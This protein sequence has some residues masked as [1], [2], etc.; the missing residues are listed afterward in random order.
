[1]AAFDPQKDYYAVLGVS[2]DADD[3]VIKQAYRRQARLYHPDSG[4]GNT[5]MLSLIHI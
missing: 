5:D 1:M 2:D 3:D 4:R